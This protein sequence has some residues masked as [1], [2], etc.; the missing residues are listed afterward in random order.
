M[1]N[2]VLCGITMA[3]LNASSN[4]ERKHNDVREQ[5]HFGEEVVMNLKRETTREKVSN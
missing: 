4:V 5:H 2:V 1:L 3:E